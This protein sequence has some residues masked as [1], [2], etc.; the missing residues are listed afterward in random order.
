MPTGTPS[1]TGLDTPDVMIKLT[2]KDET[3]PR[4]IRLKA[5]GAD[6]AMF[7]AQ[8]D[9]GAMGMLDADH[10]K[11]LLVSPDSFRSLALLR[12]EKNDAVKISFAVDG[13][14]YEFEKVHGLWV[15]RQPENYR[16]SNQSDAETILAVFKK[17]DATGNAPMGPVP[18]ENTG[19]DKPVIS[20]KFTTQAQDGAPVT[21]GPL[22]V[23]K[24][25]PGQ[26]GD[27]YCSVAGKDGIFTMHADAVDKV[28]DALH[29]VIANPTATQ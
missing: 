22:Y 16:L 15:V 21:V 9:S 27:R 26:S 5:N 23:G 20:I 18:T 8:Q 17:L 12:F 29:G 10:A 14:P 11:G 24:V 19:L 7:Y 4:E 3:Q 13:K 25:L 2:L 28:R 6:A 1:S